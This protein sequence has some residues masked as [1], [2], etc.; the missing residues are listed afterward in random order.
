[1]VSG[2]NEK[3]VIDI[4]VFGT[5]I[6]ESVGNIIF[7]TRNDV[8]DEQAQDDCMSFISSMSNYNQYRKIS[9][10]YDDGRIA[11]YIKGY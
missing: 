4:V 7:T 8:T 2:Q 1:M 11:Q 5:K 3:G 9:I 6:N 10:C